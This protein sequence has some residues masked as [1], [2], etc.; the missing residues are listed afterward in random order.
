MNDIIILYVE[1]WKNITLIQFVSDR[2]K[3]CERKI[4]F[5]LRI[6]AENPWNNI[7]C[8]PQ[9]HTKIAYVIQSA[10]LQLPCTVRR[11][12][13]LQLSLLFIDVSNE[14]PYKVGFGF[15]ISYY[16]C[17]DHFHCAKTFNCPA[18]CCN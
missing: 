3:K 8:M 7:L 14:I 4:E 15:I 13:C 6:E 12:V 5:D 10:H 17:M 2:G 18:Q 11:S 16:S 1:S 9:L